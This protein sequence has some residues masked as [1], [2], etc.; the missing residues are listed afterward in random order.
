MVNAEERDAIKKNMEKAGTINMRSYLLDMAVNGQIIR[1]ET[2]GNKEM[3]R[4]L[5]NATNNI[6]QI[7]KRANETGNIYAADLDEIRSQYNKLWDQMKLILRGIV[8]LMDQTSGFKKSRPRS[9]L[10][11]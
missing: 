8:D 7:A 11:E 4:L 3:V 1:I 6:N 5:S 10:N 9:G 2:E